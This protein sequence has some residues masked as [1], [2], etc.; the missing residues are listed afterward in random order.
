MASK[1][2]LIVSGEPSGDL[3]ASNLVKD[4]K[5]LKPD[6]KF[7]GLGGALSKSAGV[8]IKYDITEL[9][10]VGFIEVFKNIFTIGRVYKGLLKTVDENRPDLAILVDYPGFNLRLAGELKKRSIPVVYY[11]SPQIWAWGA[12]RIDII[13]ACVKRVVVFFK[14][15]EELYKKHGIDAECVG[16]PLIDT[17]RPT[18]PRAE[19]IKKY[20]L[21]PEKKTIVLLPGSR[22]NE[23]RALLPAMLGAGEI[24]SQRLNAVQF[25][26]AKHPSLPSEIYERT[27]KDAQCDAK[28]VNGDIYNLVKASDFAIVASGTATLETAIL[29]TPLVLVYKTNLITYLVAMMVLKTPYLGLVNV[30]AKREIIPELWQYA[31]TPEKISEKALEILSSPD[32]YGAMVSYLH[33]IVSSLGQPGASSRAASAILPLL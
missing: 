23:V 25:V 27:L 2:I 28:I 19:V 18:L 29:G 16:H 7:F 22:I 6:L 30:I 15:E 10:V 21:S 33:N 24:I 17:V 13:K 3:H 11:I 5:K 12:N 26:I 4:L 20:G 1:K 32:R 9:A 31:V 14:F 8:E